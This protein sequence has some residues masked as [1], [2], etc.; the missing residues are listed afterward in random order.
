MKR[1]FFCLS[2][3]FA[4]HANAQTFPGYST[5]NYA[6]VA[7]IVSN[8]ASIADSR[9]RFDLNFFS[10][11]GNFGADNISLDKKDLKSSV[12]GNYF[13]N[14]LKTGSA[15]AIAVA[16]V[17]GPSFMFNTGKKS[18]IA[19][20]SRLRDVG[21]I[22]NIDGSFAKQV[23]DGIADGV[24]LPFNF[25]S[26]NN[27][28]A[29]ANTWM[30]F[31]IT[32]SRELYSEGS[33]FLKGGITLKYLGGIAGGQLRLDQLNGSLREDV[34]SGQ[35]YFANTTGQI[36]VGFSRPDFD[37]PEAKLFNAGGLGA[38]IGLVYEFRPDAE[39]Y[40]GNKKRNK[41]KLRI[42]AS[43]LDLGKLKSKKP[44]GQGGNY[45]I[46]VRGNERLNT[47]EFDELNLEDFN[48]FFLAR[49]QYFTA[50]TN[51]P[52]AY[53][54]SLPTTMQVNLDYHLKGGIYLNLAGQ[55][56]LRK[57]SDARPY[58][59]RFYSSLT[60][61]PRFENKGFGVY[62]PAQY[63]ALTGFD[64]GASLRMGPLFVGSASLL[65]T[66]T[67]RTKQADVQL[68]LKLSLYR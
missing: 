15:N 31:G 55:L 46:D 9:F 37:D 65:K 1:V 53:S 43:V 7:G 20:S 64:M 66:F 29:H 38:D 6:G 12:D 24:G 33:N 50:L 14:Q 19:L 13:F 25:S 18:A 28:R 5:G 3:A 68:G 23:S 54:F 48:S 17:L 2:L 30:E 27:M 49:P 21:N 59:N 41:Y 58:D 22:T 36:G 11:H 56:P 32:Y 63:N 8:P 67:G 35:P 26:D 39:E 45:G 4:I 10:L 57:E 34:M 61:T 40:S 42:G 47:D 16:D 51:I 52:V 60:L 62:L 44:D